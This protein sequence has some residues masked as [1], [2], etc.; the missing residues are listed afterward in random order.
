VPYR[1]YY[2]AQGDPFLG[3]LFGGIAKAVVGIGKKAL[4]IGGGGTDKAAITAAMKDALQGAVGGA[5]SAGRAAVGYI[6]K[7]KGAVAGIAAAAAAAGMTVAQYRA[8]QGIRRSPRMQV[9]NTR[10]LR[11][12]MRRVTGFAREARKVMSFT[13][14]HRMKVRRKR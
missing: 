1:Q 3:G 14:T 13:K 2:S 8:S 6:G 12:S 7:H 11:R 9:C 10:A 4:G 5:T